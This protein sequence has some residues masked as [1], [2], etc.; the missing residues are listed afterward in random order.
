MAASRAGM[1]TPHPLLMHQLGDH[2][3]PPSP[4][5]PLPLSL[6]LFPLNGIWMRNAAAPAG[7]S[8]SSVVVTV[9]MMWASKITTP[10]R[11][12]L[13]SPSIPV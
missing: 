8:S 7:D 11:H 4:P 12:P 13:L 1:L 6:P 2:P 10:P 9:A 5:H 3:Y